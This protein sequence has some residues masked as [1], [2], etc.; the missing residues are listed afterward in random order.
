MPFKN[1]PELNKENTAPTKF[2]GKNEGLLE[3]HP[4]HALS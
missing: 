3:L 2:Q 4:W 1:N